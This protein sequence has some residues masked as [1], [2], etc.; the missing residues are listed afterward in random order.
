MEKGLEVGLGYL[1]HDVT[2]LLRRAFDDR[3]RKFALTRAQW[4]ILAHLIREDGQTQAG[5]AAQL[6]MEPAPIGR[7][8]DKL[9]AKGWIVRRNDKGDRRVRRVY[10]TEK[11]APFIRDL[12]AEALALYSA[13]LSGCSDAHISIFLRVLEAMRTNLSRPL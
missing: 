5:L 11:V 12:K 1:I 13:S 10:I 3:A 2:R 4:R 8:L 6:E 9:E 7:M